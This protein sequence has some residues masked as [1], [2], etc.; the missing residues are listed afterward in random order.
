MSDGNCSTCGCPC[1]RTI[2]TLI[3]LFGLTF[4]LGHLNI[5][6]ADMVRIIWPTLIILGGLKKTFKGTPKFVKCPAGLNDALS[7]AQ[8]VAKAE[9]AKTVLTVSQGKLKLLTVTHIG[10]V[11]DTVSLSGHPDVEAHVSAELMQRSLNICDEIAIT[12]RC[13]AYRSGEQLF[14]IISNVS[15]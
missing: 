6:S 5:M 12:D 7:R 14:Q 9:S 15:K 1:H 2:G 13:V 8:I 3:A 10:E 4:L 11:K